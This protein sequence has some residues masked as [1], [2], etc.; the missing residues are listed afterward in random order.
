MN[1]I[2]NT[3]WGLQKPEPN[4]ILRNKATGSCTYLQ[5]NSVNNFY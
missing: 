3:G 2:V 4:F 5:T 1:K